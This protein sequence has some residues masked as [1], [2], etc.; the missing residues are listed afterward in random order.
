MNVIDDVNDLLKIENGKRDDDRSQIAYVKHI[1]NQSAT[2]VVPHGFAVLVR[3]GGIFW[4]SRLPRTSLAR[5]NCAVAEL[6]G[7]EGY[8]ASADAK[9]WG[10]RKYATAHEPCSLGPVTL[11]SMPAGRASPTEISYAKGPSRK[12][13]GSWAQEKEFISWAIIIGKD[14]LWG[15]ICKKKLIKFRE[16]KRYKLKWNWERII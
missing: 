7:K 1:G 8:R 11:C 15:R 3:R 12:P 2:V 6:E 14:G 5:C 4:A 16:F 10:V 13:T 9:E